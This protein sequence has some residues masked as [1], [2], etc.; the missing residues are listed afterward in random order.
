M[1]VV[2]DTNVLMAAHGTRG[3]CAAIYE[4]CLDEHEIVVSE[5]IL[6]ELARNLS[7]KF[8]M[9][10]LLANNV[11]A[12]VREQ[13]TVVKPLDV[14]QSACR[15]PDDLPVLGTLTASDAECLVTGDRDLLDLESYSG[16]PILSPR[17]FYDLLSK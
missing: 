13:A 2:L 17:G 11:T 4:V 12:S 5:H 1:K 15:D 9:P 10:P 14:T 7:K 6:D 3:L 8:K 16:K